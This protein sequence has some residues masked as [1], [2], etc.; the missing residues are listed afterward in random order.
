MSYLRG[1]SVVDGSL[2][3]EGD[4]FVRDVRPAEN[5]KVVA[6]KDINQ[7]LIPGMHVR[8]KDGSTG[9]L[10]DSSIVETRPKIENSDDYKNET[11]FL[12]TWENTDDPTYLS[13]IIIKNSIKT[14]YV[15][16]NV[17]DGLSTDLLAKAGNSTVSS[18]NFN[19]LADTITS[20]SY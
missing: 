12:F 13:K 5:G 2:Y 3:V 16:E 19:T 8:N 9:S 4:L 17:T 14:I 6:F 15:D 10:I 18:D 1:N 11:E 7:A 20:W